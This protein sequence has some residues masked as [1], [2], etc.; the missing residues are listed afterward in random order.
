MSCHLEK[1]VADAQE[2]LNTFAAEFKSAATEIY[3]ACLNQSL[4]NCQKLEKLDKT[5]LELI[6]AAMKKTVDYQ[7]T[8]LRLQ[9]MARHNQSISLIGL[10]SGTD[11]ENG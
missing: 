9:V 4:I 2:A 7:L 8:N 11:H 5:K 10:E 3:N 6:K 1:K